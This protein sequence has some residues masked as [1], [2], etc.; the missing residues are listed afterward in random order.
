MGPDLRRPGHFHCLS[1]GAPDYEVWNI[2]AEYEEAWLKGEEVEFVR[3][4][5]EEETMRRFDLQR[6]VNEGKLPAQLLMS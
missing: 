6:Q 3:N 2:Q 1:C 5:L 4:K